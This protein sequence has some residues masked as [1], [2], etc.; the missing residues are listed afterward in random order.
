ML[1]SHKKPALKKL[2]LLPQVVMH[3]KKYGPC[4]HTLLRDRAGQELRCWFSSLRQD[5]KESFIDS[6]VMSAIKEWISPLPDKS[7]PAL[8]IRE[9]LLRILMEVSP[10]GS[11]LGLEAWRQAEPGVL[12]LC[13]YQV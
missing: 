5:L 4:T 10:G 13:S 2:T 7:L 8:R 6:G 12:L 9:E 3:L 11:L 1:N